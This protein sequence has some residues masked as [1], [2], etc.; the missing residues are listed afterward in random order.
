MPL[1]LSL[2]QH[3]AAAKVASH[4]RRFASTRPL[5]TVGESAETSKVIAEKDIADFVSISLDDNPIHTDDAYAK[6]T[7]FKGRIAHGMIAGG[8]LGGV[9]GTKLPGPG[10][11]FLKNTLEFSHPLRI[12]DTIRACVQVKQVL[13][14]KQGKVVYVFDTK[15]FN[16]NG[17]ELVKGEAFVLFQHD[18]KD[19]EKNST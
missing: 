8:L 12:G 2:M 15:C 6:E 18:P 11:I 13:I 9:L 4:A 14:K 16:Q 10:S 5:L 17:T 19:V 7:P 1:L 3:R